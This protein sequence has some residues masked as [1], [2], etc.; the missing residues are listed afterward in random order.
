[1]RYQ[2]RRVQR[3][4]KS[5]LQIANARP[6]I[7]NYPSGWRSAGVYAIQ[8]ELETGPGAVLQTISNRHRIRL[9]KPA[10]ILESVT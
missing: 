6:G 2:F 3:V 7:H 10:T 4:S 5:A 1:M 9:E 8:R